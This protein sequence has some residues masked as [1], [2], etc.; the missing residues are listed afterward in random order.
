MKQFEYMRHIADYNYDTFY[1]QG[2]ATA[3]HNGPHG[4]IDTE[5]RNTAHYLIIYCYLYKITLK[6]KYKDICLKFVEH[7]IRKQKQTV[8]GAIECMKTNKFDHINGLIGQG[9]VIEALIYY[10]KTF[11]YSD[12]LE[13][14]LR[15]FYSQKYNW[16]KHLWERIEINGNNLGFDTTYNHQVWF[17]ACSY[18]LSELSNDNNIDKIIID[19]LLEGSKRDFRIYSDGL[20]HHNIGI[21]PSILSKRFLKSSLK[22]L[23]S[24]FSFICPQKLDP[25]YMEYAYHL[26]DMYGFSI[27]K[28]KYGYLPIFNSDEYKK[29][30]RYAFD[31]DEINNSCGVTKYLKNEKKF[32][33]FSY[34]YNSPAF[35]YPY[36]AIANGHNNIKEIEKL[37]DI[38]AKLMYDINTAQM[39]KNQPDIF[40]WNARTYEII[41]YL[42]FKLK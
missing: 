15:I 34:S 36:I 31:L 30:V 7:L 37:Y 41:R 9:W 10:Y 35:E 29:A 3:G 5:V 21:L 20:L 1:K 26:F 25:K 38:Q 40:T 2:F 11:G 22:K 6:Q 23:L 16:N 4:H 19:F 33:V 8:S 32:N 18:P 24:P 27:L 17:A 14:A 28:E 39:T 13:I 12:I 42:E